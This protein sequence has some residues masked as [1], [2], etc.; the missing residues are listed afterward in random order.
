MRKLL[1]YMAILLVVGQAAVAQPV[2]GN[3]RGDE[4]DDPYETKSY[5]MY[6]LNYLSDNVYLGRKDSTTLPYVSPYIGY[7]HQSGLY[8]KGTGSYAP[9]KH[10]VDL[11]V[12]EAGYEHSFGDH[13]NSGIN[14]DKFFY[15]KTSTSIRGNT[16]G[17]AGIFGQYSNDW[18]QPQVTFNLDFSKKT[19]YVLTLQLD[20]EFKLI[21]NTLTIAPTTEMNVGTRHFYDQYFVNRLTKKDKTLKLK[22]VLADAGRFKALDYELSLPVTYRITKWLFKL[23]PTYVIPLNPVTI[24]FPKQTFTEKVSN[25]FYVELDIC[26]R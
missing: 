4:E 22:Q 6:G 19:D 18:V 17:S 23:T 15:N 20:H 9:T 26:H 16:Q 24:T 12:I 3:N 7:H 14:V 21:N 10:I 8:I 13:F 11:A 2:T 25:S 1:F 5:F